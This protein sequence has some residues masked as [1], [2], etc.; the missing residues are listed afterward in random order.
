MPA[1]GI[2]SIRLRAYAGERDGGDGNGFPLPLGVCGANPLLKEDRRLR[3]SYGLLQV[4]LPSIVSYLP[5]GFAYKFTLST[6]GIKYR[7]SVIDV[8]EDFVSR[9]HAG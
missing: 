8:D 9:G 7:V 6:A 3:W 4:E 1:T 2:G 5:T